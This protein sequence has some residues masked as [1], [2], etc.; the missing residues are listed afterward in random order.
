MHKIP[1]VATEELKST[2]C[3]DVIPGNIITLQSR[4]KSEIVKSTL[5]VLKNS[6]IVLK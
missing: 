4:T 3:N 2:F 6:N 5:R 1:S